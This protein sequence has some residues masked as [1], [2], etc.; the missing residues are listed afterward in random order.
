VQGRNGCN[1]RE[2]E[3]NM[4]DDKNPLQ[5]ASIL[6]YVLDFVGPGHWCFV[7]E[8]CWLWCSAYF[9]VDD[10]EMRSSGHAMIT[11]VP[12]MTLYSAVFG[13]PSRVRHAE[14]HGLRCR[15]PAYERAA[16][17]Y[18]D[19]ATLVAARKLGMHYTHAV[20]RGA[21]RCNELAVLQFLCAQ[22]CPW[23]AYVYNIAALRGHAAICAYLKKTHHY[24]WT[25][26]FCNDV[27]G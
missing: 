15:T 10:V 9:R 4:L 20:T 26:T 25:E 16:G 13:S 8:V 14:A 21:A 3:R 23:G 6:Q 19:V 27:V 1:Q 24:L 12:Q 2:E 22:G 18:A 7:A 11:C 5:Q 17:M